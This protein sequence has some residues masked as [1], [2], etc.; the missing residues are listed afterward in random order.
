[1]RSL[2]R[3]PLILWDA[4][5]HDAK[6]YTCTIIYRPADPFA[7]RLLV[8]D[9]DNGDIAE[10]LFARDLLLIGIHEPAGEGAVRVEPHIVDRDYMTLTLPATR[11]GKEF[12]TDLAP[13]QEFVD[14]TCVL[15]PS[16]SELPQVNVDLD[17]WLTGVTS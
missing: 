4:D 5:D 16:G 11:D 2:I 13:L 8:P 15:V 10:I 17:R 1:M 12:Y 3:R 14:D 7:V 6:P 9:H